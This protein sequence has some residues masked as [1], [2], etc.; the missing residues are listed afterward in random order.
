MRHP[1]LYQINTR[2]AL[3]ERA[4]KLGRNATLDDLPDAMLDEIA[5]FGFQWVWLLGVW[6]TGEAGRKVSRADAQV[7]AGCVKELPDLREQDFVGSPFAVKTWNTHEDF[8][9]DAALA[10]IRKRLADRG[11]KLLLDFVPNHVA[12]DHPWVDAHPEY[13][14][15]GSEEDLA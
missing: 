8:G 11:L 1:S 5:A 12:L 14:V 4:M 13:F 2:V 3:H 6:Q 15:P 9:G 7:R 10:R